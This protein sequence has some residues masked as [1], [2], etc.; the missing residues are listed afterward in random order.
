MLTDYTY[1][2]YFLIAAIA[3]GG[4]AIAIDL[5]AFEQL[6]G[7]R[8]VNDLALWLGEGVEPESVQHAPPPS[9]SASAGHSVECRSWQS[10]PRK[11]HS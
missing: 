1:I 7:D 11:D 9:G 3:F 8:R 2:A 5:R 6:T 4:G 10:R